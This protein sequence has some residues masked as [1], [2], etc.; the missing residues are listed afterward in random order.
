[1][2]AVNRAIDSNCLREGVDRFI[3]NLAHCGRV[4]APEHNNQ[5]GTKIMIGYLLFDINGSIQGS[6][7]I[8]SPLEMLYA[9][10]SIYPGDKRS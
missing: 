10:Y 2:F 1:V 8:K 7:P 6:Y 5:R 4:H 3:L 9:R